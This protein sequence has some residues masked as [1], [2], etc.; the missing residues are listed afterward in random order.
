MKW[1]LDCLEAAERELL[2]ESAVAVLE[3]VGMRMSGARA[4]NALEEWDAHVDR[5]TGVVRARRARAPR[6][7]APS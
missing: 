1:H 5:E 2:I 4:L 7:G 3:R 6:A